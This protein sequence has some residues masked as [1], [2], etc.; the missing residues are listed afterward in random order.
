MP[1]PALFRAESGRRDRPARPA[2][3]ISLLGV[4]QAVVRHAAGV[5]PGLGSWPQ[6]FGV[7]GSYH[8]ERDQMRMAGTGED[9]Y[10][11]RPAGGGEHISGGVQVRRGEAGPKPEPDLLAVV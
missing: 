7:I 2:S 9:R 3:R 5:R 11:L 10:L 4:A 1:R 8:L 6:S